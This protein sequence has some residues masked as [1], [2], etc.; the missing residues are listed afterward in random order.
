MTTIIAGSIR[1]S[2]A[3]APRSG[4]AIEAD[5]ERWRR[6]WRGLGEDIRIRA[7]EFTRDDT[8]PDLPSTSSMIFFFTCVRSAARITIGRTRSDWS[9][10]STPGDGSPDPAPGEVVLGQGGDGV[11]TFRGRRRLAY[12]LRGDRRIERTERGRQRIRHRDN[13]F[14]FD[15]SSVMR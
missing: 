8:H 11:G 13:I 7:L 14:R 1:R 10:T 12:R 9:T 6:L 3:A 4:S 5:R 15:A 2:T